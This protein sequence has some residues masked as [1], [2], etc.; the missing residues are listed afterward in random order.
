VKIVVAIRM[1]DEDR[2]GLAAAVPDENVVVTNTRDEAIRDI[3]DAEAYVPGPWNEDIFAAARRLR[4]VHFDWAGIESQMFPALA[5]SDV[6]VTNAAGVFAVPM[7]D[8]AIGMMLAVSRALLTCARRPPEQLWHAP[9]ARTRITGQVRELN[10]ATLGVVGYGGIGREVARRAKGFG[11]RVLAL[12]RRPQA[13]EFA[14][15]V[16]GPDRLDDLLRQSDYLVLSC[17]L[18]DETRGLIGRRE[19][20]LMKPGSVFVNVARGAV[21]DESALID[22]LQRG[23][24][25]GAGLDVTAREPLPVE[26]P[27]W[28]ME[29]VVVTPH[30]SGFSPQTLRRQFALLRENVRRFAAGE[31]LLNVVDKRAGY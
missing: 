5:E 3:P 26:S 14:D 15:E 19:L 27:L 12:R 1:S 17:A 30:V 18:T 29:N 21:V 24:L 2:A 7:A 6:L 23:H 8:H 20:A 9:G 22:A 31:P 4:W 11:M 28:T 13:D 10:G 16:W 25:G